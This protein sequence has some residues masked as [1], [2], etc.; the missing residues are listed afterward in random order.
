MSCCSKES[1]E[2]IDIREMHVESKKE[3][4]RM[5]ETEYIPDE[6]IKLKGIRSSGQVWHAHSSTPTARST[7]ERQIELENKKIVADR[8][9]IDL[10]T[11]GK[12][13]VTRIENEI[14]VLRFYFRD[15]SIPVI[16]DA[17]SYSG[18]DAAMLAVAFPES[19]VI[20]IE[21]RRQYRSILDITASIVDGIE[22]YYGTFEEA[23]SKSHKY[24][25]IFINF[26]YIKDMHMDIIHMLNLIF[27]NKAARY[28][29]IK[30]HTI[31]ADI[32]RLLY[33]KSFDYH[34]FDIYD[35]KDFFSRIHIIS[36]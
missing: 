10:L 33:I 27:M 36:C 25:F 9:Q 5:D 29:A 21:S 26:H 6:R 13:Q 20:A 1:T 32:E 4:E 19:T 16:M 11:I 8:P 7:Q 2:V 23:V 18:T 14:D 12:R 15:T 34:I 3:K 35:M 22:P 28:L 30:I 24:D 17:N 31:P